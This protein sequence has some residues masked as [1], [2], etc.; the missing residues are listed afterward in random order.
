[1]GRSIL[2]GSDRGSYRGFKILLA[3]CYLSLF[4]Y[5]YK[6]LKNNRLLYW[7]YLSYNFDFV[8][9]I[10]LSVLLM[11]RKQAK[12]KTQGSITHF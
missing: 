10:F 6:M 12:N 9:L 2:R 4:F 7:L 8:S 3:F 5:S 11:S 1:M